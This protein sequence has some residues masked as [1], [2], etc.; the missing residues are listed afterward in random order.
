MSKTETENKKMEILLVDD[1]IDFLEQ[2]K[3]MLTSNGYDVILAN[4]RI[5]AEKILENKKPDFA[6]IDLMMAEKDDGFVLSY[7]IKKLYP[8]VPVII[9]TAVTSETG[10]EFDLTG[11]DSAWV[12][13]DALMSKPVRFE[14]LQR[15]IERLCKNKVSTDL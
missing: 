5:D 8:D 15:E 9:L 1:D 11:K 3:I 4:T 2:Q 13:A 7:H 6:I 12:K 14:Q 10:L